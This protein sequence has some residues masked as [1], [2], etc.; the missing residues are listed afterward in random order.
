MF[1]LHVAVITDGDPV[2][3]NIA[4]I[5]EF[6]TISDMVSVKRDERDRNCPLG[7]NRRILPIHALNA[8]TFTVI[9]GSSEDFI[10][11]SLSDLFL[12]VSHNI[13]YAQVYRKVNR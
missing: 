7:Q 8:A 3:E 12:F 5:R 1:R 11:K 6:M 2:L 13:H 9:I 10:S 4:A